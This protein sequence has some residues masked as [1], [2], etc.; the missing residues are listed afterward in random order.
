MKALRWHGRGDVRL[1]DVPE[2]GGLGSGEVVVQVAYCGLCGSDVH[3]YL[4]GPFQ[5]P[6]DEPHPTT[7]KSAPVTLGHEISGVVAALGPDVEGLAVGDLVA[8][9]ALLPCG[10]CGQCAAGQAQRCVAL[11]HL[12]MSA[13]GGLAEFVVVPSAMVARADP[14]VGAR[15]AAL[16]EPF[17]V[18]VH[19][20]GKAPAPLPGSIG[21]LGAGSIG[22]AVAIVAKSR[23][24]SAVLFDVDPQRLAHARAL[25]FATDGSETFDVVFDCSGA[26]SGPAT[27]L[28]LLAPGGTLVCAGLPAAPGPLDI[29]SLVLKEQR[30]V[31]AVG[32][33]VDADLRPA[34]DVLAEHRDLAEQLITACVPLEQAVTGGLDVLAGADRGRHCKILVEVR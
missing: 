10:R 6:V 29:A 8:L 31:G 22:L 21:V 19:A 14:S 5:I 25:G 28:G 34:L 24:A 15:V 3:E 9:N 12:G 20:V 16:A 13:D 27:A 18:A 23:G 32:H 33:T 30:V 1:D 26:V 4:H 2:P 11:G 17:A 7:G